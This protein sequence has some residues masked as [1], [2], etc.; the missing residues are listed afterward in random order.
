M[1]RLTVNT[2]MSALEREPG[3]RVIITAW[4]YGNPAGRRVAADTIVAQSICYVIGI[5][6]RR[7]RHLVT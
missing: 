5:G 7:K 4:I 2:D 3:E 6:C 1:T